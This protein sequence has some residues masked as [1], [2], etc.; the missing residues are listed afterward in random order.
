[1][2]SSGQALFV[3]GTTGS[4]NIAIT[5][6]VRIVNG[7]PDYGVKVGMNMVNYGSFFSISRVVVYGQAG[8]DIIKTAAQTINGTLT[9]VSVPVMFFAGSGN[10]ILNLTGS[11]SNGNTVTPNEVLVGSGGMDRIIG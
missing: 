9:N 11:G 3:G 8:N 6:A 4:D 1:P 2:A 10:D 5:P 7:N